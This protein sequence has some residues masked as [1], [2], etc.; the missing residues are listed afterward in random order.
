MATG[1]QM[2]QI[3]FHTN[4][5][6]IIAGLTRE[7]KG[8]LLEML[9]DCARERQAVLSEWRMRQVGLSERRIRQAGLRIWAPGRLQGRLYPPSTK[10]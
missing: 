10:R 8:L 2:D 9:L 7:Q 1:K 6:Y 5:K 3:I 4:L